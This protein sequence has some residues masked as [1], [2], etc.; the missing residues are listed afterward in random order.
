MKDQKQ[1]NEKIKAA[2]KE[3]AAL[4]KKRAALKEYISKLQHE[5]DSIT[6]GSEHI[7]QP[8]EIKATNESL[9]KTKIAIFRS[10]FRGRE[11]VFPKRF[12]S[13]RTQK[14]GYQPVCHNEWI[15]P[16]CKKP[17][18]KCGECEN[19]K[20]S[21]VTD[22]V[23]RNHLKGLDPNDRY[24]RE[25]VIGVYPMLLDET[26]WFLAVDFDKNTWMEDA[27]AYLDT[28]QTFQVPAIRKIKIWEW[29]AH[30]DFFFRTDSGKFR[31]SAGCI[32]VDSNHGRET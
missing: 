25:F 26:C 6:D 21:P 14:S 7:I 17:K 16:F 8:Y 13:K 20:F 27:R 24:Q 11:D 4:D 18:T 10:L 29:R 3:L 19:R 31:P 1:I 15:K 2:E 23:V 32:H 12:E 9:E 30:L 5:Q 22:D 28:C